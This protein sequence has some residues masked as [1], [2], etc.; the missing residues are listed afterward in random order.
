VLKGGH[1]EGYDSKKNTVG[2]FMIRKPENN[3]GLKG[4]IYRM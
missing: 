4:Q 1:L 2:R 3:V